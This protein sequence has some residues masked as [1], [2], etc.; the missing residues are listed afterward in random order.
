VHACLAQAGAKYQPPLSLML[1]VAETESGF[2]PSI[3]RK[4][5]A[6]GNL[7]GSTD[8]GLMQINS[9][10][11][12]TL[13]RHGIRQDHL[14]DACVNADVG[15]WILAQNIKKMGY[16]W[17][18]VGAYN[19][20]STEKRWIYAARVSR[21]LAKYTRGQEPRLIPSS[22]TQVASTSASAQHDKDH[23]RTSMGIWEAAQ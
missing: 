9:W 8:Y 13:A 23:E 12:P 6:A 19:A 10:W 7:D 2:N 20:V 3:V 14:F 22:G 16:S 17:L 4:P 5:Y 21:N 18:A 11:L 15:A 1:A